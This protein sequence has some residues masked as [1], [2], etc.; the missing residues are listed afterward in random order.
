MTI[1]RP[2]FI[3]EIIWRVESQS[4][5]GTRT[6]SLKG[7]ILIPEATKSPTTTYVEIHIKT[8]GSGKSFQSINH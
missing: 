3:E 2:T 8:E 6:T 1:G 5:V 7:S 4:S